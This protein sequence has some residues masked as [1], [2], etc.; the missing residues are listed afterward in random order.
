[1]VGVAVPVLWVCRFDRNGEKERERE[2]EREIVGERYTYV[3]R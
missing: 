1:M 3:E 2:R